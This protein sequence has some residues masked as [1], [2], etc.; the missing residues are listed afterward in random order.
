MVGTQPGAESLGSWG[1]LW[2]LLSAALFWVGFEGS[3]K[4]KHQFGAQPEKKDESQGF[5]R[6]IQGGSRPGAVLT[7]VRPLQGAEDRGGILHLPDRV[8]GSQSGLGNF[9]VGCCSSWS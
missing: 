6:P 2:F 7:E 9:G 5:F 1:G 4:D 3:Q 8:Q